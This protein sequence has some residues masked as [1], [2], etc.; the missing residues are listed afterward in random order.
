MNL[1]RMHEAR[2]LGSVPITAK[3]KNKN[4]CLKKLKPADPPNM[5]S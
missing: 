4:K 5:K 1:S 2:D 3:N